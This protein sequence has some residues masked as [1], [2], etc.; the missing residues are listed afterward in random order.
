MRMREC[1]VGLLV[2]SSLCAAQTAP[3]TK[4]A[5]ESAAVAKADYTTAQGAFKAFARGVV[6]QDVKAMREAMTVAPEEKGIVD[7]VLGATEGAARLEKAVGAKFGEAA[8]KELRNPGTLE[9]RMTAWLTMVDAAGVK[10]V[11][12]SRVIYIFPEGPGG[13]P[14]SGSITMDSVGSQWK[15]TATSVFNLGDAAIAEKMKAGIP[16]YVKMAAAYNDVAAEVEAG[17]HA[18]EKSV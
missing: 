1:V 5:V 4:D 15:V 14:K 7:A 6:A 18:N 8:V 2:L 12:D 17:K 11:G 16:T 13:L 9:L 10:N 3:T